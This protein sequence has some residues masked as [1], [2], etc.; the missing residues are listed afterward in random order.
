M[1]CLETSCYTSKGTIFLWQCCLF[2]II[3][4]HLVCA[5]SLEHN[6]ILSIPISSFHSSSVMVLNGEADSSCW[7]E[8]VRLTWLVDV[9]D[10][11]T[12]PPMGQ[13]SSGSSRACFGPERVFLSFTWDKSSLKAWGYNDSLPV[14]QALKD[15]TL[16]WGIIW[17]SLFSWYLREEA[18][19]CLEEV[20]SIRGGISELMTWVSQYIRLYNWGQRTA[21]Q[22][23]A[24]IALVQKPVQVRIT[25]RCRCLC[26]YCYRYMLFTRETDEE[27]WCY[28]K[29]QSRMCGK[30]MFLRGICLQTE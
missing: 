24:A 1:N 6:P 14:Q 30:N 25:H 23:Q 26:W 22:C 17:Q 16:E 18:A 28:E 15:R 29:I 5:I 8:V 20:E 11:K 19:C 10:E 2:N 13:S 7:H 4:F 3:I 27:T 21:E 12:P 9:P